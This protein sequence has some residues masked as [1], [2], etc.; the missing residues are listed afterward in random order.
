MGYRPAGVSRRTF[1]GVLAGTV[2]GAIPR[3]GLFAAPKECDGAAQRAFDPAL[4]TTRET[5]IENETFDFRAVQA[6]VLSPLATVPQCLDNHWMP[7]R[8]LERILK[9]GQ[10]RQTLAQTLQPH[11]RSEYIRCLINTEQVVINRGFLRNTPQVFRDYQVSDRE[12]DTPQDENREAFKRLLNSGV[13]VPF[14]LAERSPVDPLD[15]QTDS[16]GAE[17]WRQICRETS[18]ICLR[19]SWDDAGNEQQVRQM[20]L[21]YQRFVRTL[22]DTGGFLL[23]KLRDLRGLET[24]RADMIRFA[25]QLLRVSDEVQEYASKGIGD[26][27]F[28]ISMINREAL[29]KR[30]VLAPDA[31]THLG[32]Y[33]PDKPFSAE[34]KLLFDLKYNLNLS[35]ALNSHALTPI[36]T[37]SRALIAPLEWLSRSPSAAQVDVTPD[38]LLR[39]FQRLRKT[40]VDIAQSGLTFQAFQDFDL[41]TVEQVR[42]T[43]EW[44]RYIQSVRD[45]LCA[46]L[47]FAE[48][49][50][51]AN[52]IH[53]DY[54]A[55]L[56][57]A[58]RLHKE[59]Q[60][61]VFEREWLPKITIV[62]D[63][64]S[65]AVSLFFLGEGGPVLYRIARS[66]V[67]LVAQQTVPIAFRLGV[68]QAIDKNVSLELANSIDFMRAGLRDAHQQFEEL[69]K[70]LDKDP[71]FR[72][73]DPPQN[74]AVQE[75]T[76]GL[77]FG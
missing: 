16:I 15:F 32:S 25:E 20:R 31:A 27:G 60:R 26:D 72:S 30:F 29:Y 33:D 8:L 57:I 56:S 34:L 74:G 44:Q 46:P 77:R 18:P 17:S 38:D 4:V 19:L 63:I 67:P 70:M 52:A 53:R 75:A 76:L 41:V 11:I 28:P 62:L 47:S 9:D 23:K 6:D 71:A 36:D 7:M 24:P 59:R 48:E 39:A 14:L 49:G 21:E 58:A 13:I 45:L 51:G 42:N 22:V 54:S 2:A 37:P 43:P 10:S 5:S 66:A 61:S 1:I 3:S 64:G 69:T 68:G 50:T 40:V 35:D 55:L 73:I 12:A 65:F